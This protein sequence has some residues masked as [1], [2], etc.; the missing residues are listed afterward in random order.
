VFVYVCSYKSE[1]AKN[2]T[3]IYYCLNA[4]NGDVLWNRP[5]GTGKGY[6]W[7]GSAVIGDY[8]VYGDY[9]SVLT[10]V[11]MDNGTTVDEIDI[12][13]GERVPFNKSDAGSIR[14]SVAY[15]E[16]FVYFT[17]DGGYVWKI[18][19]DESRGRF[20]ADGWAHEVEEGYSASRRIC[21]FR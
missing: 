13:S 10:S 16:G 2:E 12:T 20:T 19:F 11:Y 3:G 17:S 14:S 21:V 1:D 5:S 15:N 9:A 7:A 4:S 18:G 8:L 6:Y